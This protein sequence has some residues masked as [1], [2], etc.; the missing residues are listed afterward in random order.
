MMTLHQNL[1]CIWQ[2]K[3]NE[4]DLD[5]QRCKQFSIPPKTPTH[6]VTYIHNDPNHH[7]SCLTGNVV[8]HMGHHVIRTY[9]ICTIKVRC[10]QPSAYSVTTHRNYVSK[11]KFL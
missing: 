9:D 2:A 5:R 10:Q 3:S 7:L 1:Y 6:T 4:I 11:F 8:M